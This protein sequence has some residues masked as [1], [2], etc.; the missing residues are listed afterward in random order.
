MQLDVQDKIDGNVLLY[1]RT[2][3][4]GI[5]ETRVMPR[6]TQINTDYGIFP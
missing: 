1:F 4:A 5:D 2:F 6:I 3:Q